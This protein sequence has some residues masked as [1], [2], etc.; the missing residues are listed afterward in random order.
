[1]GYNLLMILFFTWSS[2]LPACNLVK[3][4]GNFF[5][6]ELLQYNLVAPE[7]TLDFSLWILSNIS[8]FYFLCFWF[9]INCP[10]KIFIKWSFRLFASFCSINTNK[11]TVFSHPSMP[12]EKLDGWFVLFFSL[13]FLTIW[14]QLQT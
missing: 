6:P 1:M 5:R 9:H 7:K 10:R 4:K 13:L 3:L 12:K 8:S 11:N 14:S 2:D